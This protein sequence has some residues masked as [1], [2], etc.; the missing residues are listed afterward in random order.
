MHGHVTHSWVRIKLQTLTQPQRNTF[1]NHLET[2]LSYELERQ[3][4][5]HKT[6]HPIPVIGCP[7]CHWDFK[8]RLFWVKDDYLIF[9]TGLLCLVP[10]EQ[11]DIK[12]EDLREYPPLRNGIVKVLPNGVTLREYQVAAVEAALKQRRGMVQAPTGSGKTYAIGASLLLSLPT[13]ILWI[14]H[15]VTL[16]RQ[17]HSVLSHSLNVPIGFIGDNNC[18]I[19]D[20]TIALIQSLWSKQP[21]L[22]DYLTSVQSV[23]V[24]EC[25]RAAS[26]TYFKTLQLCFKA[27]YRIGLSATPFRTYAPERL[28]LI[29]AL[30]PLIY[31]IPPTTLVQEK[32]LAEPLIYFIRVDLRNLKGVSEAWHSQYS[33][34][35]R[36]PLRNNLIVQIAIK[37][38][39]CLILVQ[40]VQHGRILERLLKEKGLRVMFMHGASPSEQRLNAVKA[41]EEGQ[42]HALV[43]TDIFS[44]GVDIP[45][46]GVLINAAGMKSKVKV[47]QRVG[48]ALRP[49]PS[50]PYA[51]II[52]FIDDD[53]GLLL[54]HSYQRL[55]VLKTTFGNVKIVSFPEFLNLV[56]S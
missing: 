45:R 35:I 52:D 20:I 32:H 28:W 24:D 8:V 22:K 40:Q 48:R 27:G 2:H 49:H 9:P 42:I 25:H 39:P 6:K 15:T 3:R 12:V 16:A 10:L 34:L 29:G 55:K 23:I 26:R 11:F 5:A 43:A 37:T 4:I 18:E 41:L 21:T 46:V 51:L 44:E 19:R 36:H 1:L 50:K 17:A 56:T 13:P 38:A 53:A 30:G 31:S 33:A 54:H 7:M 14:T 47:L